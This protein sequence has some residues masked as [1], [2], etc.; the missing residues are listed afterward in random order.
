VTDQEARP[1][2]TRGLAQFVGDHP[3]R[4]PSERVGGEVKRAILDLLGVTILG[5]T[6]EAGMVARK[7]AR[8][9]G[10]LGPSGVI[11]GPERLAPTMAAL[12]NGTAG[13]ALDYDDIGLGVGHASVA[14]APAALAIADVL[15]S[16]GAEFIDAMA[17]GYEVAHR[18]V[19]IYDDNV[20]GPYEFGFHKPSVYS[21]FGATAAVCRLLGMHPPQVQRAFGI[22]AS[23]SGG[24]RVNFGTMTKPLHAGIANRTGVEAALLVNGGF[25]ASDNALEGQYGW[26]DAIC[27][28]DGDLGRILDGIGESPFAIEE[29]M[30][31]KMYPCCGAN[32]YAIDGVLRLM[33][34]Q[35]LSVDDVEAIDV[36][37]QSRNLDEVLVYPWPTSGLQGKFSLAYN[38]AAA[39]VDG[40]VTVDTF[41]DQHL[42]TLEVAR[43]R[44]RVHSKQEMPRNGALIQVTTRDGRTIEKEQFVLRGS[45]QEPL[46]WDELVTKFTAT[47]SGLM[48]KEDSNELV[49][50]IATLD[51]QGDMTAVTELLM[52]KS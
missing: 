22:A 18:L 31:Y 49:E 24:L 4:S 44:V 16:T 34:E 15:N 17:V 41:T 30:I 23:E 5:A 52:A 45:L 28:K 25:T 6:E 21:V 46:T 38:V 36:T 20:S 40:A 9:Q 43:Q 19:L 14:I 13:H 50:R 32:H 8:S 48:S 37:I 10:A 2:I 42:A 26:F 33:A 29:G 12:V 11:G 51:S 39:L 3:R 1:E 27:R 35:G 7:Y 47:T